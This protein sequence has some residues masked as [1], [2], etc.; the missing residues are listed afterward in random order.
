MAE[1]ETVDSVAD[2]TLHPPR[3]APTFI[4]WHHT[5]I[6]WRESIK[7]SLGILPRVRDHTV[8][9]YVTAFP[10]EDDVIVARVPFKKFVV[11]RSP[12]LARH[13]LVSNQSNYTKSPDYDMLAVA[14]GRGLVT[15]LNDA[16]WQR[17]RRLVQPIFAKRNV[18][19]FAPVMVEAATDAVTRIRG[20]AQGD[21]IVD[22]NAEMNRL[23]LDITSR[24]M[25]GTD[26]T[27]P[28]SEVTLYRLLRF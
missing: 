21:G 4:R 11:V 17:N 10:G 9:D 12:E 23:T 26:I 2:K 7:L 24:T 6:G 8:L 13:V 22:V 19:G 16:L 14:F 1:V 20:L 27:G 5:R 18:D 15:D 3:W 28:M 25:F